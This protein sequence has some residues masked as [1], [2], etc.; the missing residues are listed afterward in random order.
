MLRT[1]SWFHRLVM[2]LFFLFLII[3]VIPRA[4]SFKKQLVL[5]W[6]YVL[7]FFCWVWPWEYKNKKLLAGALSLSLISSL[8]NIC[9]IPKDEWRQTLDYIHAQSQKNDLVLLLPNYATFPF[10]Y[11]N[12][13][14]IE[15]AGVQPSSFI[16][17][18]ESLL[19][20]HGRLWLVSNRANIADPDRK[21]EGW[22]GTKAKLVITKRF[23]LVQTSLYQTY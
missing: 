22:L 15:R 11:Y 5:L 8:I 7:L 18:L 3:S 20:S 23:Y 12:Q 9:F 17:E 6:P 1:R 16:P 2:F 14:K 10:D 13:G 4:Y 21:I 19:K